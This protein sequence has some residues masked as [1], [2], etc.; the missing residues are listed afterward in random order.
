[1]PLNSSV[2]STPRSGVTLTIL[3]YVNQHVSGGVVHASIVILRSTEVPF[4]GIAGCHSSHD[5]IIEFEP[6]QIDDEMRILRALASYLSIQ[7]GIDEGDVVTTG[8]ISA[9][10][11]DG[12]QLVR[13][14]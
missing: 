6:L 5:I 10:H 3:S 2:T 9:V 1:M 7:S 4:Y 8:I 13:A 11:Q 12:E 14:P